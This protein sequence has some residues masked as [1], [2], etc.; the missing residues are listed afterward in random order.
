MKI[1]VILPS[2]SEALFDKTS[3]VIFG[4]AN[5]QMYQIAK[6]FGQCDEVD[7]YTLIGDYETTNFD[8]RDK[9]NLIKTFRDTDRIFVKFWKYHKKLQ[10]IKPDAVLQRGL[11]VFSSLFA[12][13]CKIYGI[14]FVYMFASDT[15]AGGRYQESG[16]RA[17]LFKWLLANARILITQNTYQKGMLSKQFGR[18]SHIIRSGFYLK[19]EPQNQGDY[20]LWV[21]RHSHL[22]RPELFIEL[23]SQNP[24]WHFKM[25]CPPSLAPNYDDLAQKAKKVKNLEFIKFVPFGNIDEYFEKA[26][27]FVNTS[28]YEGFP[29]TFL[30]ATMNG[31][32]ILSL[33]VNP[34]SLLTEHQIG[35]CC[36]GSM[37]LLQEKLVLLSSNADLYQ[38]MSKNA[39]NYA[40]LN[41]DI[42]KNVKK[43]ISLISANSAHKH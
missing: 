22:K 37:Q 3:K 7:C 27:V 20:V 40:Q 34:D 11:T 30:Q 8:E 42:K 19:A 32:P 13:Y 43:I 31:T 12:V 28:D 18:E 29:Q 6:E 41:H 16:K 10:Q 4:G 38:T 21:A 39:F 1:A 5:V 33:L 15:E 9:F 2:R 25:V 23:A 17:R 36:N 26:K 24:Q 14:S 35:F